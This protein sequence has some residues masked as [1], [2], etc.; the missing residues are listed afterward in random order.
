MSDGDHPNKFEGSKPLIVLVNSYAA[1]NNGNKEGKKLCEIGTAS[2][3]KFESVCLVLQELVGQIHSDSVREHAAVSL[4]VYLC[5]I[6]RFQ[7]C[8]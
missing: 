2:S 4:G 7:T 3:F 1:H 5:L 6:A 8:S